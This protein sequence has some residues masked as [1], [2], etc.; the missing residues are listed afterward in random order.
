VPT[1]RSLTINGTAY[2]LSLDRSWS[3]GTITS[4]T[5]GTGLTGGTITSSGTLAFDT[6]WGDARYQQLLTNP[7]TGSGTAGQVAYFNGTNSIT[8]SPTFAFTPTSQLLV[9]NSVT[10]ASAIARGINATPSLTAAANNDVLVGLDIAPTFTNGAFTGVQNWGIR[11]QGSIY[12]PSNI[13]GSGFGITIQNTNS[14]SSALSGMGF[15]NDQSQGTSILQYSSTRNNVDN[16]NQYNCGPATI[17]DY[18]GAGSLVFSSSLSSGSNRGIRFFTGASSLTATEK[19]RI[20]ANGNVTIQNGGT[21]TDAGFRLDVNGTARATTSVNA[22]TTVLAGFGQATRSEDG[23]TNNNY[24]STGQDIIFS[25][26]RFRSNF[27]SPSNR[28]VLSTQNIAN[29]T[30]A[31]LFGID[32]TQLDAGITLDNNTRTVSLIN[33]TGNSNSS[34]YT[35]RLNVFTSGN[36]AINSLTDAGFRL[37]INGTARV[38]G[39]TTIQ[40]TNPLIRL[41][42][43]TA[44]N[45]DPILY[46][47]GGLLRLVD[48]SSANKGLFINTA[49]GNASL[50]MSGSANEA[51]T[52]FR[53]HGSITAASAIARG[54]N[55]TTTLVAAANNDVL[56]GLDINPIFTNGAFTGVTNLGLRVTGNS[57]FSRNLNSNTFITI[58]NTT[59]GNLSQATLGLV[60]DASAGSAT[61][62]KNS[63]TTGV[64]KILTVSSAQ[65]YNETA[66]DIAILNDV[67]T[68]TIKMA[69]GASS[70][71]QMQIFANGNVGINQNT[72]AGFRLDVNGTARVQGTTTISGDNNLIFQRATDGNSLLGVELRNSGGNE[73]GAFK[74]NM[75]TGEV[76][77][78]ATNGGGFFPTFFTNGV[79]GGRFTGAG[80][81][82]TSASV[83]AASAIARGV[84]FTNT[85]V[86]AAN[87]DFLVGLDINPTFTNGAFTGV[88]NVGLRVNFPNSGAN[89]VATFRTGTN[90]NANLT[91]IQLVNSASGLSSIVNLVSGNVDNG[92]PYFAIQNRNN[93]G[94]V[95][96]NFRIFQSGNVVIQN[97]GTFTDAGFRLDVNGTAR[98]QGT[99]TFLDGLRINGGFTSFNASTIFGSPAQ[100]GNTFNFNTQYAGA[101]TGATNYFNFTGTLASQTGGLFVFF[102]MAQTLSNAN[103]AQTYRGFYYNPTVTGLVANTSHIAFE[104]TSGNVLLGTTSGNVA[105]GTSTLGTATELTLGGSQTASSSIARGQLLNTTLVAAANNDVL[106]GLDI[107]PT[108]TNG[109]FTGVTNLA[110]RTLSGRLSFTG[111]AGGGTLNLFTTNSTFLSNAS[112]GVLTFNRNSSSGWQGIEHQV[113]GALMAYDAITTSGEFRRFANSGGYFQTFYSNGVEA[114]RLSTSQ[115]LLIGTTTDA[116]FRLDVNGTARVQS[117]TTINAAPAVNADAALAVNATTNNSTG[118]QMNGINSTATV[119]TNTGNF[120]GIN[121]TINNSSTAVSM[122]GFNAAV[123]ISANTTTQAR[124]FAVGGAVT[125]SGAVTTYVGYDYVDVFKSG[126]GAV[127]RQNAIRIANLTAGSTANIGIL[128]NNSAG[129]AVNGTWD[130][131]SQSGN[132]SY[133][134]GNLMIGTTTA[135]GR[136][137]IQPTN[138]QVGMAISG[139]SLTG[140]NAQSL[141]SLSQTWNTTGNPTAIKLDVTN[142]ASGANSYLLDLQVGG[143]PQF[144]VFKGGEIKTSSPAGGVAQTWKLGSVQAVTP[145]SPNR[146]IEVEVNGTTYYLHAKTTND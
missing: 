24:F 35:P 46:Y 127:T 140:S 78:G 96:E 67:A 53:V 98:V 128:F 117:F 112:N 5:G 41:V 38:Q 100:S 108:F 54:V 119:V 12:V 45:D 30:V 21:H 73:R 81:F 62:R 58:S 8:S 66:G 87:N 42:N 80:T 116:G 31:L 146:T 34:T 18:Q 83:T 39:N 123:N 15:Q 16:N 143:I 113:S 131:Y 102:N 129:T 44:T 135:G 106:V 86:A 11:S 50:S 115:N 56:V 37:D 133:L 33:S 36:V 130:I 97:G 74:I 23:V 59:A 105:I 28:L 72:D 10:A 138:D 122:L 25:S 124:G 27:L 82:Q 88:N 99:A 70:T 47:Q 51:T 85:L 120:S 92:N 110:I 65:I 144:T 55:L 68:G 4:I 76:R 75:S 137:T 95:N 125:G 109:A 132:A 9:N 89:N 91:S 79:E 64:Y 134:A 141:V 90:N 104:N 114:I 26:N 84:N 121:S 61:F 49:V 19:V 40:T 118:G 71:S 6:T 57:I 111:A 145:T 60:S 142:T 63:S 136:F 1:S 7:V 43:N 2:D 69:A 52:M 17:F 14:G 3:V 103:S 101:A 13:N 20:F 94:T 126:S 93:A 77:I 32:A 29:R 48:F 139:S 107:N 22:G